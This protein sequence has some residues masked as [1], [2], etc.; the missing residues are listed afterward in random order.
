MSLSS[1]NIRTI[2]VIIQTV[3]PCLYMRF[4]SS[5]MERRSPQCNR[6]KLLCQTN[7]YSGWPLNGAINRRDGFL[8]HTGFGINESITMDLGVS[9]LLF[10][11]SIRNRSDMFYG[12]AKFLFYVLR[13]SPDRRRC[14]SD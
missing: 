6:R 4:F 7:I 2:N 1:R 3:S 11:L 13:E 8:F 5:F 9:Y 10:K 14:V 12:R